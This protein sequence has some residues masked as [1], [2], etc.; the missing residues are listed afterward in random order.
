[1]LNEIKIRAAFC[2]AAVCML[3]CGCAAP[4]ISAVKNNLMENPDSGILIDVPFVKQEGNYCGP[5]ALSA[6]LSF[7]SKPCSQQ[8]IAAEIFC[9]DLKGVLNVDL[10]KLA[11][12]KG[13]WAKGNTTDFNSLKNRLKAGI[14][15]IVMQKLHPFILGRYH[16]TVVVGFSDDKRIIIEHTG[17]QAFVIRSYQG[18]KRNW[19]AADSWMLEIMP[20]EKAGDGLPAEDSVELGVLLEREGQWD[21]SLKRY[22]DALR[23]NSDTPVALYNIGNVYLNIG[24]LEDAELSYQKAIALKK[25]FPDCYNNMACL[26][27]RKKDFDKAHI[28]V[29]KALAFP[30]GKEFYYLDTKAQIY[31]SQNRY[32]DAEIFFRKA[33]AVQE[34]VPREVLDE[35]YVF[36]QEKFRLIGKPEIVILKQ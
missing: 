31:Y 2:L 28:F 4:N 16:F 8:D 1:M 36:W 6:V 10:E 21:A 20:K 15:V 35:F 25:D 12:D 32:E 17:H 14:P 27:I 7:W 5:A 34:G 18:F 9:E 19:Y 13:L 23:E 3:I 22:Y 11:K 24:Q 26:F 30:S 33:A 29:D